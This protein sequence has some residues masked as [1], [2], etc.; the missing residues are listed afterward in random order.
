MKLSVNQPQKQSQALKSK[1][2]WD[3]VQEQHTLAAYKPAGPPKA[4]KKLREEVFEDVEPMNEDLLRKAEKLWM[5][6]GQAAR[7]ISLR[8]DRDKKRFK[9]N[10][11]QT[12]LRDKL[13]MKQAKALG[14]KF[15]KM[16]RDNWPN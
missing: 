15:V 11:Y 10:R 1:V 4:E 16:V 9:K 7:E 8:E 14:R 12:G 3:S 6:G 13:A 2:E 5:V